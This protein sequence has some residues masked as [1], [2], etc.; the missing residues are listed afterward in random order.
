MQSDYNWI[1][2]DLKR[3]FNPNQNLVK[4]VAEEDSLAWEPPFSQSK[5][6]LGSSRGSTPFHHSGESAKAELCQMPQTKYK[7]KVGDMWW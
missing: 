1:Q 5:H 7:H 2:S 4:E 6:S 3:K